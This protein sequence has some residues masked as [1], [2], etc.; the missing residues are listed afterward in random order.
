[1]TLAIVLVFVAGYIFIAVEGLTRVNK[2]AVALLTSVICWMLFYAANP[3]EAAN[4]KFWH[5]C[6]EKLVRLFSS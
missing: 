1:M 6:W 2:T 3:S 4:G 5:A